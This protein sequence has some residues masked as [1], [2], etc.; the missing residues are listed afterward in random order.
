MSLNMDPAFRNAVASLVLISVASCSSIVFAAVAAAAVDYYKFVDADERDVDVFASNP[1]FHPENMMKLPVK[2]FQIGTAETLSPGNNVDHYRADSRRRCLDNNYYSYFEIEA[3]GSCIDHQHSSHYQQ[4]SGAANANGF[5][6]NN[7]RR[8]HY[9]MRMPTHDAVS[10]FLVANTDALVDCRFAVMA[11]FLFRLH[12]EPAL[13]LV[14]C[15]TCR[16]DLVMLSVKMRW[17]REREGERKKVG[18]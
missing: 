15:Q 7:Y 2:R 1:R 10:K 5:V 17:S 8:R 6:V 14:V 13:V 9:L 18:T 12:C 11:D 16:V 4:S 3:I